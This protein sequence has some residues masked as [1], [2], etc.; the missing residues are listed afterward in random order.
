MGHGV[1][2]RAAAKAFIQAIRADH[3]TLDEALSAV[4]AEW[5]AA[6][7]THGR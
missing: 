2:A 6:A 4:R 1:R 5:A 7:D 3:L